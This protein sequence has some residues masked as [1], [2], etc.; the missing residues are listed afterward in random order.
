[1]ITYKFEGMLMMIKGPVGLLNYLNVS[2]L[3][4]INE[5]TCIGTAKMLK[6]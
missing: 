3:F 2:K 4:V 1:M 6:I 5:V